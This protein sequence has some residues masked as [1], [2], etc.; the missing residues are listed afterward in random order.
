MQ[1]ESNRIANASGRAAPPSKCEKNWANILTVA[2]QDRGYIECK[3]GRAPQ[4]LHA[5]I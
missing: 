2:M 4:I 3:K 5:A 1:A